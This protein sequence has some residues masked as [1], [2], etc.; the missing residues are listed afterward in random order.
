[1]RVMMLGP[2]PSSLSR[3]DGGV[4]AA[5]AY[6]S[7]ALVGLPG[8]ELIGV[9]VTGGRPRTESAEDL[10][11]PVHELTLER[12]SVSTFFSGQRRQLDTLLKRYRPDLLHAQGADASGYLAVKSGYPAVVTIHGI[13]TECARLRTGFVKRMRELAQARIT[14]H[15]V[16]ERARHVI[17]ISPYVSSYYSSRLRGS[18]YDVPN[19]VAAQFFAVDRRPE[20]GRLLFAGRISRGKGLIDLV[21]AAAVRPE[22]FGK[23]I[24]AGATPDHEFESTLRAEIR[25]TKLESQFEFAGLLDEKAL[26]TEFARA[27]ALVLPSYQET[28]PMVIQQA[29]AAGLP[30]IATGVGGIPFQ[31][32]HERSGLLF[33]PGDVR[34]LAEHLARLVDEP[35]LQNELAGV[36][37]ARAR[38]SFSAEQVAS[39]TREV[40]ERVIS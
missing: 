28:A 36:A 8:V 7:Q 10:G 32:E 34:G 14:E 21:R 2:F 24:L 25:A 12:F 35:R 15:Y 1:M 26:L 40:Y 19:A 22:K 16:V 4:A 23:V 39:A 3:V 18:V 29:M 17:A 20:P 11:W 9:R 31:I 5:T 37:R 33:E 13:L 27:S 30:V 38:S 6:V